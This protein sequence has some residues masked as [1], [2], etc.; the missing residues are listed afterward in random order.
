MA[1][2]GDADVG[3]FAKASP[4]EAQRHRPSQIGVV[5]RRYVPV[6]EQIAGD[7]GRFPETGYF[8]HSSP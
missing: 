6:D 5:E 2:R 4:A 8:D 7:M 3:R 1:S